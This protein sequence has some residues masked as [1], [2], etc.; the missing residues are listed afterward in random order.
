MLDYIPSVIDFFG[1]KLDSV[2]IQNLMTEKT[3][4]DNHA[5]NNTGLLF[6]RKLVLYIQDQAAKI[7]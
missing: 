4:H 2:L 1:S 7:T 5:L 3:G 6:L